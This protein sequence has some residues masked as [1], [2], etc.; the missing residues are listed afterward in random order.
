MD[1]MSEA[2]ISFKN[3]LE[4]FAPSTFNAI[5]PPVGGEKLTLALSKIPVHIHPDVTAFYS[6]SDGTASLMEG[7]SP[8]AFIPRA[9]APYNLEQLSSAYAHMASTV[10]Y[11]NS[12]GRSYQIGMTAHPEWVPFA[13][14][15]AGDELLLDHRDGETYGAILEFDESQGRYVEAWTS[16][17]A[18][19]MEMD[20]A[21]RGLGAIG[22]YRARIRSEDHSLEWYHPEFP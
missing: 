12:L 21:V 11:E 9:Y 5:R 22:R 20:H 1:S 13:V 17:G 16:M 8:S 18:M 19:L 14:S 15:A 3:W 10:A 4:V 7:G 6:L 2:W